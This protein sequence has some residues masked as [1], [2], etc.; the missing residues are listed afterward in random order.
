MSE[1]DDLLRA[2]WKYARDQKE[3]GNPARLSDLTEF[4]RWKNMPMDPGFDVGLLSEVNGASPWATERERFEWIAD[5]VSHGNRELL[6][7]IGGDSQDAACLGFEAGV[8]K[9][10]RAKGERVLRTAWL[11]ESETRHL[12]TEAVNNKE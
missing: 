2:M 11:L 3:S 1:Y 7:A 8:S 6:R 4:R 12:G 10:D 9:Y 5:V